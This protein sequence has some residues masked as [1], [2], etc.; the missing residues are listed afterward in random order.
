MTEVA[1]GKV[2]EVVTDVTGD[3]VGAVDAA[4]DIAVNVVESVTE[5]ATETISL[6]AKE[7]PKCAETCQ[8]IDIFGLKINTR[9]LIYGVAVLIGVMVVKKL[10]AKKDK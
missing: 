8:T 1:V 5:Q 4:G 2:A 9:H 7:V 3:L 10:T 6:V